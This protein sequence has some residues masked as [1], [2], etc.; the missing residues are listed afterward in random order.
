MVCKIWVA[1][2]NCAS[3]ASLTRLN[4]SRTPAVPRGGIFWV[5]LSECSLKLKYLLS[6]FHVL[7]GHSYLWSDMTEG[8]TYK[9]LLAHPKLPSPGG[10]CWQ[11]E[12]R[13]FW[14]RRQTSPRGGKHQPVS[15]D[16]GPSDHRS[17]GE[18]ASRPVQVESHF[19][20]YVFL[21][22]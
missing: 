18:E 2:P 15:A 19:L 1:I 16:A 22:F 21:V 14:C 13:A 7:R 17:G 10:S 5:S 3:L 12:Y 4:Q 11:W 6:C 9:C 20:F 8:E